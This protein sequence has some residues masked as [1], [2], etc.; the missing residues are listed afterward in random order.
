MDVL[1]ICDDLRIVFGGNIWS[2]YESRFI[3]HFYG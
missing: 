3:V 2:C 1:D